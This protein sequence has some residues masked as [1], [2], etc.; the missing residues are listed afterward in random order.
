MNHVWVVES[1]RL[2]QW[3][4]YTVCDTRA[5]ARYALSG[6]KVESRIRKYIPAPVPARATKAKADADGW[7]K[8]GGGEC[9]LPAGTHHE[10]IFREGE[11]IDYDRPEDWSWDHFDCPMNIIAYRVVKP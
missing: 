9:P 5:E 10:V 4:A 7:I 1:K 8:W 6:S 3:G 2:G 11:V